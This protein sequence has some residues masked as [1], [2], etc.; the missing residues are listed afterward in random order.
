MNLSITAP[1]YLSFL[2]FQA[3]FLSFLNSTLSS[4]WFVG[5]RIKV[6]EVEEEIVGA[7]GQSCSSEP[8][9][10]Q[11]IVPSHLNCNG[12]EYNW[13]WNWLSTV[14]FNNLGSFA[15]DVDTFAVDVNTFAVDVDTFA[16]DVNTFAVDDDTFTVDVDTLAVDVDT[17]AVDVEI[18]AIVDVSGVD[19]SIR[20]WSPKMKKNIVI[21]LIVK[22]SL[23]QDS[24]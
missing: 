23:K 14:G 21:D 5:A 17:F 18:V 7:S 10:M 12:I 15:A 4:L 8:S 13:H 3:V 24:N 1:L 11:W 9:G 22:W 19:V 2:L 6:I 20:C 16:V